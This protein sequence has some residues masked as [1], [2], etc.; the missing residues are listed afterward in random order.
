MNVVFTY[1]S[2]MFDAVWKRV[3]PGPC[4][5]APAWL[6]GYQ[7][8]CLTGVDYPGLRACPGA[9]VAGRA[10]WPVSTPDLAHLDAFEG[11][12]YTRIDVQIRDAYGRPE[13]AAVYLYLFPE[14]CSARIWQPEAFD[15]AAF[16]AS[17]CRSRGV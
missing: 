12:E 10:Y 4:H 15:V 17:Y 11:S 13:R 6:D 7:R 16:V 5:A 14:R 3:V 9:T 8:W 1:G 2:L